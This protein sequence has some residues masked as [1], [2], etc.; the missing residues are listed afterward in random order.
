M[1]GKKKHNQATKVKFNYVVHSRF[2]LDRLKDYPHAPDEIV[3]ITYVI[4]IDFVCV[5][6]DEKSA[7]NQKYY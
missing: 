5:F 2:Q 7:L 3:Y 1:Y 6:V 4:L